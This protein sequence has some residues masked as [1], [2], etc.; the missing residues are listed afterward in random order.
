MKNRSALE[1]LVYTFTIMAYAGSCIV[2][3]GIIV[4]GVSPGNGTCL[5]YLL[6]IG[7]WWAGLVGWAKRAEEGQEDPRST[8]EAGQPTKT[9]VKAVNPVCPKHGGSPD[10]L[11][12]GGTRLGRRHCR[13]WPTRMADRTAGGD[14]GENAQPRG[15]SATGAGSTATSSRHFDHRTGDHSKPGSAT[16]SD[17]SGWAFFAA[18]RMK[19]WAAGWSDAW[20]MKY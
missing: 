2:V 20:I 13:P 8:P 15:G 11:S 17:S 18:H 3:A 5:G 9:T 12:K 4:G 16:G 19:S 1:R 7:K 6:W 14:G 10:P